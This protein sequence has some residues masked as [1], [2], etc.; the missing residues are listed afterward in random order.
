MS[1]VELN[2]SV[3]GSDTER[4]GVQVDSHLLF[5]T[6]NLIA[7]LA[8]EG[9]K[10]EVAELIAH[11]SAMLR[12]MADENPTERSPLGDELELAEAYLWI[13][14]ARYGERLEHDVRVQP[15]AVGA[16]V[17][18]GLLRRLAEAAIRQ[19]VARF[20]GA[21][22]V[23]IRA[24]RSGEVLFLSVRSQARSGENAAAEVAAAAMQAEIADL[25]RRFILSG[26]RGATLAV[27]ALSG[28]CRVTV[29]LSPVLEATALR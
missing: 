10:A 26:G 20:A 13:E 21:W 14:R 22:R 17:P 5:N 6:L 2:P 24:R 28:G 29:R 8:S 9:R 15:D 7:G 23:V 16:R 25:T 3:G 18:A 11:L 19:G 4:E 1:K 12:A 27:K